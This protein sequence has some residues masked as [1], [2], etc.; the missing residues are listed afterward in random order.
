MS[1]STDVSRNDN[2]AEYVSL[3]KEK[4]RLEQQVQAWVD[5]ATA[6]HTASADTNDKADVIAMRDAMVLSLRTSLGV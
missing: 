4:S 2:I 5:R 3:E 6:L 1:Y